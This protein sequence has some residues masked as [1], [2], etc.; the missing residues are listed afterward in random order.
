MPVPVHTICPE[1]AFVIPCGLC[2][3]IV[4]GPPVNAEARFKFVK[5]PG[6]K[7]SRPVSG[8]GA[9]AGQVGTVQ[10]RVILELLPPII[11]KVPAGTF[12]V[13][14]NCR[15]FPTA[16]DGPENGMIFATFNVISPPVIE[17]VAMPVNCM[18]WE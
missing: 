14:N 10:A 15:T 7:S 11:R 5:P 16:D 6:V 13:P 4:D 3:P 8:A 18:S 1:P 17:L 12:V 2:H 9:T